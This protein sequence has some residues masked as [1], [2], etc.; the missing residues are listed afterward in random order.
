MLTKEHILEI[1]R[2][3]HPYLVSEYGIKRIGIFGSY[4]KREQHDT[5]DI[6]V[7]AEFDRP[8]GLKFVEFTEYLESLFGEK[9]DVLTP[10][11][12]QGIRNKQIAREIQETI[13]YV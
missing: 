13:I 3:H 8:L 6:D 11:G 5:S 1:L 9:T 7:I 10:A 2:A 4:A 12:I